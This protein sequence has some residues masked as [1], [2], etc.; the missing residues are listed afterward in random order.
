MQSKFIIYFIIGILIT[1]IFVITINHVLFTPEYLMAPFIMEPNSTFTISKKLATDSEA[2]LII[3]YYEARSS[4]QTQTPSSINPVFATIID[5][6]GNMIQN[7][8]ASKS[9]YLIGHEDLPDDFNKN[10]FY[11][12]TKFTPTKNGEYELIITNP[13]DVK[14]SLEYEFG[15][16][17]APIASP[18]GWQINSWTFFI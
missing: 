7:L 14:I 17:I 1:I 12:E 15:K 10:G 4:E 6:A 3:S 5:P 16:Y 11:I 13:R 2:Q 9:S 8:T 18:S